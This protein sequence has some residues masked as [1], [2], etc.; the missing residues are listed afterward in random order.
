ME[1]L[2]DDARLNRYESDTYWQNEKGRRRCRNGSGL[3][4]G[5]FESTRAPKRIHDNANRERNPTRSLNPGKTPACSTLPLSITA[6]PE[7]FLFYRPSCP[8]CPRCPY[9][10]PLSRPIRS[11][12]GPM[13]PSSNV[14]PVRRPIRKRHLLVCQLCSSLRSAHNSQTSNLYCHPSLGDCAGASPSQTP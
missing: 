4:M 3:R 14:L 11:I 2:R 7:S 5:W 9:G 13:L 1:V 8:P 10:Q 12:S 6:R